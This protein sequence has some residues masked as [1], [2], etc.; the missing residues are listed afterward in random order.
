MLLLPSTVDTPTVAHV[1]PISRLH[2]GYQLGFNK[3]RVEIM[4]FP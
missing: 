3:G 1:I 4:V 2:E